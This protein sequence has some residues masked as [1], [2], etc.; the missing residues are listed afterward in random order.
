MTWK[1]MWFDLIDAGT[2][3]EQLDQQHIA[4]WVNLW[5]V[6]KPKQQLRSA[7]SAPTIPPPWTEKGKIEGGGSEE[8]VSIS[9]PLPA[10]AGNETEA[11]PQTP[12]SKVLAK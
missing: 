7:P 8:Q 4:G 11:R 9:V 1:H 5:K 2:P 10:A 3:P 6:L 12:K